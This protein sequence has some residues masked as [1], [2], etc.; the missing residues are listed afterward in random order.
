M[1]RLSVFLAVLAL[2][3]AA[4]AQAQLY[5]WIDQDGKV[6]YGDTPPPGAKTSTVKAP[7]SG[8]A[9]AAAPASKDGKEARKES[10]GPLTAAERE[11]EYR[12]RQAEQRKRAEKADSEQRAKAERDE[13]CQ[14]A[15]NAQRTL[16]SGQRVARTNASG[17]RYFLDEKQIA[18]ELAKA[19]QA[20]QQ[21]CK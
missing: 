3:C 19:Q 2:A 4:G 5:K 20:A 8:E 10:K 11:Q 16:E 21:A 6:R 18:Q 17:E 14:R 15:R 7:A 12:N 9:P 13:N 1:N